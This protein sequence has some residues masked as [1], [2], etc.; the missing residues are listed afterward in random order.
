MCSLSVRFLSISQSSCK[1]GRDKGRNVTLDSLNTKP[2]L[3]TRK[4]NSV[5][6]ELNFHNKLA[7]V[8]RWASRSAA[9]QWSSDELLLQCLTSSN[10]LRRE[11]K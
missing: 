9:E 11:Q 8:R 5:V 6:K 1:K 3:Q 2:P 4:S 10:A 7:K